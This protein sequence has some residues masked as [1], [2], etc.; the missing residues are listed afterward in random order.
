[1]PLDTFVD[2]LPE[3]QRGDARQLSALMQAVTGEPPV[4]WGGNIVGF[5]QYAQQYADGRQLPWPLLAFSP[6]AR[7]LS[8]YLM[9]G[10]SGQQALLATLGPHRTGKCCLYIRRLSDVSMPA[11]RQLLEASVQALAPLRI[12]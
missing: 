8:L 3:A 1:M 12:R 11:L 7:E 5:G 10:V 9:D 6:R 4:V 2:S